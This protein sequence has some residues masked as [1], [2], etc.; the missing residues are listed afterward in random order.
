MVPGRLPAWALGLGGLLGL[1]LAGSTWGQVAQPRRFGILPAGAPQV[2][3]AA[4]P[5]E[6]PSGNDRSVFVP[7]DR[8]S[9]LRL[10]DA[11]QLLEQERYAEAVR[12]LGTILES[13]E[14]YFF[15][16]EPASALHR[17]L[18]G[19]AQR[20]LGTMPRQGRELYELQYGARAR[21]LLSEAAETGNLSGVAEV[22]RRFF[23]TQAG[24]E[25]TLLLGLHYLDHDSPLA[26]ALT[27]RRLQE[28]PA[29]SA[30]FE[31]TLSVAMA[32][33]WVRAGQPEKA[34]EVLQVLGQRHPQAKLTVGGREVTLSAGAAASVEELLA[35]IGPPPTARTAASEQWAL[36]RGNPARNAVSPGGG[37]LLSLRWQVLTY[38]HPYVQHLLEQIEQ[39]HQQRERGYDALPCL[40]PLVVN[41]VV[42][43]RTVRNLL[44][45][46]FTTGKRIWEVPVEDPFDRGGAFDPTQGESALTTQ[47]ED[48][49]TDDVAHEALHLRLWGDATY[50]TLSSD[51][52]L[53]FAI[54]DLD[55]GL[56]D[57][58]PRQVNPIRETTAGAPHSFNRL[59]A[60]DLRTGKLKWHLGGSPSEPELPEAG[61]F[62]LGPPLPLMGELYVLGEAKGEIRLMA[63]KAKS[64]QLLWSQQLAVVDRD[65]LNDATR[66]MAG[67]SP[68]YADGIL[69]CPTADRAVVA[70]ELATRS[71]LWGYT[72]DDEAARDRRQALVLGMR[73]A[74]RG[75]QPAW[76]DATA[77]LVE[78]H[79]LLTPPDSN[80]IQC[81]SL[82]D[83]RLLWS[84]P[85][86]NDLYLAGVYQ[87]NVLLVGR[88]QLRALRLDSGEPAWQGETALFPQG[89][90]PSGRGFLSGD[91]Y[92][93]PLS[94]AE[95]MAVALDRGKIAHLFKARSGIVPGNLL[96][97]KGN[98]LSQRADAVEAFYQLDALREEVAQR[99]RENP[100]DT[101]ALALRGQILWEDGQLASAVEAFEQSYA[102]EQ[103]PR[104]RGLLREALFEGLKSDFAHYRQHEAEIVQLLDQPQQRAAYLRLMAQGLEA[105]GQGEE[106][107]G[108]YL[109]LVDLD[110]QHRDL[111]TVDP[112]LVVQRH[113]WLR[114]QLACLREKASAETQAKLDQ[115]AQ[116]RLEAAVH[117]ESLDDLR[118]YLDYFGSLPNAAKARRTLLDRLEQEGHGAEAEWLLGQQQRSADAP[119]VAVAVAELGRLLR[120]AGRP[121]DAAVY[122]E[123]LRSEFAAVACHEGQTG[124]QLVAALAPDDA[125]RRFLDPASGWPAGRIK[126]ENDARVV[127]APFQHPNP[128]TFLEYVGSPSPFFRE[129]DLELTSNPTKLIARDGLGQT[130]WEL[131]HDALIDPVSAGSVHA[132]VQG[133]L[134]YVTFGQR[135][136]AID[137]WV[138]KQAKS[139]RVLW[140]HDFG[141]DESEDGEETRWAIPNL[142]PGIVV[143]GL[144]RFQM[145]RAVET[146]FGV[147]AFVSEEA[148][149]FQHHRELVA[150][151]PY[152]GAT[153]WIRHGIEPNGVVFGD[154]QYVLL[155]PQGQDKATVLRTSDGSLVGT[156]TVPLQRI[157]TIGRFVLQVEERLESGEGTKPQDRRQLQLLDPVEERPVWPAREFPAGTQLCVVD[158]EAV[159]S[160]TPSGEFTLLRLEDGQPL[161]EAKL[162][163]PRTPRLRLEEIHVFPSS[164]G[165]LVFGNS[166]TEED[167]MPPR[168]HPVQSSSSKRIARGWV[169]GL[170]RQGKPL[171]PEAVLIQNQYL[172]LVQPRRLPVLVFAC[173]TQERR[174]NPPMQPRTKLLFLDK[175]NGRTYTKEFAAGNSTFNLIGTPDK[176]MV[177]MQL[178]R[179]GVRLL[180]TDE[181][182][183]PVSPR[184][185]L[186]LEPPAAAKAVGKALLR[187]LPGF[188]PTP[189]SD[190]KS[191]G[192]PAIEIPPQTAPPAATPDGTP[193][194]E[195]P[196]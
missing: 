157:A 144:Q 68:S 90:V 196:G 161:L 110:G 151:H 13:P 75:E 24:A 109:Q 160:L 36:F 2:Q 28:L 108:Y 6:E 82:L 81:L 1:L 127:A 94:S 21:Q 122:Y 55:L 116:E 128:R 27:L 164:D 154:R 7:A 120:E 43:M 103:D 192:A 72:Y 180:L 149:C 179:N 125:V 115:K 40:N 142:P 170:D 188:S 102:R 29:Q 155:L 96:C 121:Q 124:A 174:T 4:Q 60:Y 166:L 117:A 44:A 30:R 98:I 25:A 15:Q 26:G 3:P 52:Q 173:M 123:R 39:L 84:Q 95:V 56:S 50:G 148:V 85:R 145:P 194:A 76:S 51:G 65:I 181:S 17:S 107:L 104:I 153:L 137:T 159:G 9:L 130:L 129:I 64:G 189:P 184:R 87:G 118:Q 134:L 106:A 183:E 158:S 119:S 70:L 187:S 146:L 93:V 5:E 92:Y 54:E 162:T 46:D 131:S 169:W 61:V 33:C 141:E 66:R 22:A 71:L 58:T 152:T 37:P 8:T 138:T 38:E 78:G 49:P 11:Q 139:P 140:S 191:E 171:W 45:V 190:A 57:A 41:D 165:Y 35:L 31:P 48:R 193:P 32:T 42:L 10:S 67:A 16:P 132:A 150:L 126:L 101:E 19:E 88:E 47:R 175:R 176:K 177:Q 147:P 86:Q 91:R 133:H 186:V 185:T 136:V 113:R 14:D 80:Q 74:V 23:H 178:Q 69:V 83:G 100:Q 111:E 143:G 59:A 89:V 163:I 97:Y 77:T 20:L 172:P 168:T 195:N 156:R 79:V 18:K 114:A 53:V 62:F 12:L 63:L 99:L 112:S 73:A 34:R 167:A 182:L 135:I 105:N